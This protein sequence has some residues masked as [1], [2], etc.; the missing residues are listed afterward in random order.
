MKI[1][2]VEDLDGSRSLLAKEL[3]SRGFEVLRA[4][5]GDGGWYL[6]QKH[7][8]FELVLSDCR[9]V[10]GSKIKDGAQL[11]AAIHGINPYQQMAIMTPDPQ[12]ARRNLPKDLRHLPV[13]RK[14]FEIGEALRLLRQPVLPLSSTGVLQR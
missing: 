14:P 13:L 7:G 3:E 9:F 8:P 1:L 4:C 12:S 5:S 11:M 2:I 10:P 6:L